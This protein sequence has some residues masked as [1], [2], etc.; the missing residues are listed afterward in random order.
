MSSLL[1]RGSRNNRKQRHTQHTTMS[2]LLSAGQM[3]RGIQMV[4]SKDT[5]NV[6]VVTF[7]SSFRNAVISLR[8]SKVA[9]CLMTRQIQH[10]R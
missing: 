9:I 8:F 3:F 5:W 4:K 6:N 7:S 2:R 1:F 10:E